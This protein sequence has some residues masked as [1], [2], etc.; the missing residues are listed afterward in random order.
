MKSS[1]I[2]CRCVNPCIVARRY[3]NKRSIV[4]NAP[5]SVPQGCRSRGATA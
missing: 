4:K 1:T 2:C 5:S 3:L